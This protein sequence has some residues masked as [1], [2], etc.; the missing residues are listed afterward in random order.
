MRFSM[1]VSTLGPNCNLESGYLSC[2]CIYNGTRA[3]QNPDSSIIYENKEI[4]VVNKIIKAS[5]EYLCIWI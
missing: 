4:C 3:N 1:A 5:S 2:S